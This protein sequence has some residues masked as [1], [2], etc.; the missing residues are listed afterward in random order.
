MEIKEI[1]NTLPTQYLKTQASDCKRTFIEF[2]SSADSTDYFRKEFSL[3]ALSINLRIT[4]IQII[5]YAT[6]ENRIVI[7]YLLI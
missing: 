7:F 4:V 1:Q 6:T 2:E 5:S 3:R